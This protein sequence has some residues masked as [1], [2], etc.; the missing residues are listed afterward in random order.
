M[1]LIREKKFRQKYGLFMQNKRK[2]I[3]I[4]ED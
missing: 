1:T 3:D 4:A 2:T